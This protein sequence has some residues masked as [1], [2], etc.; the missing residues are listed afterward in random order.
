MIVR[1]FLLLLLSCST[2]TLCGQDTLL[3]DATPQAGFYRAG[4]GVE[5]RA[6]RSNAT[7]YYTLDGSVPT[8]SSKLY[9]GALLLDSTQVVRAVAF[10]NGKKSPVLTNTY[11]IDEDSIDMPVLSLS[12]EPSVLF[13]PATGV[14]M[15]GPKASPKFPH[16]G[17]NY[18]S[19]R[20]FPA[21]IEFFETDQER[22]YHSRIGFKLFGGMSRIFPQKSFSLYASKSRHGNK[23]IRHR[24]FPEKEQ[25]KYKRLVL[26]N[27]GSDFGETH[28]RDALITSLGRDMGLEVQAYRPSVVFINGRYWGIY[29]LREKLTRHYIVENF[30]YH[31]DSVNLIEHRKDVQAGSRKTYDAM[32]TYMRRNDLGVQKH[33]DYVATQMDVENFMEYEIIQIYIDNRDAG[34]NIKFWR[35][36]EAGGRWR[37]ILFDT[38][39]GLG[40]YGRTGYKM[41]SLAFHTEPNGPKWPNPPWSTLNLRSLLQN[42]GFQ[43]QFISRFLDRIN[44][45]FDSTYILPRMDS[46]IAHIR[47]QLPRHWKRWKLQE[48]RWQRE[49]DRIGEFVRKRPD[50]MRQHLRERFPR[51]GEDVNLHVGTNGYGRVVINEVIPVTDTFGGVYFK[52]LPVMLEAKAH[53]G[54]RF[55]HWEVDSERI[56]GPWLVLRFSKAVHQVRAVFLNEEHPSAK[57]FILNEISFGDTVSGD[58]LEIYNASDKDLDVTGWTIHNNSKNVF[59]FPPQTLKAGDFLVVCKDEERFKKAFP[60]ALNVIGG[61]P[62]GLSR[63]K[64]QLMVFDDLKQPVDS[65][66]YKIEKDQRETAKTIV[67]ADFAKDNSRLTNWNPSERTGSPASINPDYVQIR[68]DRRWAQFLEYVKIGGV[69]TALFILMLLGYAK[70]RKQLRRK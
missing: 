70:V 58:W 45:T 16:Y 61:L 31:K 8:A 65:I 28:F 15:R 10:A 22:V 1:Y 37:W 23:Y 36:Q 44:Y 18:Y 57:Q 62:F 24:V 39:F 69:T 40:H 3:L 13:H 2:A 12:I 48:R 19:R 68:D 43:D 35:P 29:N 67:L 54:S 21:H 55:S 51:V 7:I 20:E 56:D 50:F 38:D 47:P 41:N 4:M 17:A 63:N 26:R 53:F 64:D 42:K 27:S 52:N 46:I 6:N 59:T 49:V 34:G 25:K 60:T 66:G 5:L 14:F 33:F 9:R 32:R 11:L 30:G